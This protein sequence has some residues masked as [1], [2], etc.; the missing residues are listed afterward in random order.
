MK[1]AI[2][3]FGTPEYDEEVRLRY[4]ILRKPLGLEYSVEQLATEYQDTHLGAYNE[5]DE[6]IACLMMTQKDNTIVKMR[7]VA[8]SSLY[9]GQGIGAFL[10]DYF[11][12]L[13]KH[14]NYKKIELHARE[15]AIPFYEKLKYIAEGEIFEEVGIPHRSMYKYL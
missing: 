12:K 3:D 7:Q 15:T 9:Q 10:V 1:A 14:R 13:A 11:E 5:Q 2:I 6:L 4:D 8:V